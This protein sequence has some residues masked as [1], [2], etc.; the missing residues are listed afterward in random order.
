MSKIK[1]FT[2]AFRG[3][4]EA[5]REIGEKGL[6]PYSLGAA[7]RN[8]YP[9]HH[10]KTDEMLYLISGSLV[11][12]EGDD[13]QEHPVK[14]GD[15]M[16]IPADQGHSVRAVED[17]VYLMGLKEFIPIEAFPIWHEPGNRKQ[18]FESLNRKFGEA[19]KNPVEGEH[20]FREVLSEKLQFRRAGGFD[21]IGKADF[22][23]GLSS[24]DNETEV[25]RSSEVEVLD[26][27][28]NVV[29]VSLLVYLKGKR[30]GKAVDAT[31][32][33]TRVFVRD[34]GEWRC[35]LWFNAPAEKSA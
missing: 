17:S 29:L 10:H 18:F 26:Y 14:P 31:F 15:K 27:F 20:F 8:T 4:E 9:A 34:P 30:G 3:K 6:W 12:T 19:E 13:G 32:R 7:A 5:M 11:F 21:P 35:V 16:L 33:N 25:I 2:G 1:V 24:P 22:L 23:K 28:E